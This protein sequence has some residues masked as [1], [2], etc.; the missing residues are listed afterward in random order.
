MNNTIA[1]MAINFLSI[2]VE[3]AYDKKVIILLDEFDSPMLKF[4]FNNDDSITDRENGFLES[5]FISTFRENPSL[6]RAIITGITQIRSNSIISGFSKMQ[7]IKST[8]KKFSTIFGFTY[9]EVLTSLT[10]YHLDYWRD[11][12]FKWYD[13]YCFS[14]S[15]GIGNPLSITKFM[16]ELKCLSCH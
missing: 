5:F 3:K 6:E 10:E 13:G 15:K 2:F 7:I 12:I 11:D 14:D 9:S 8:S 1:F 16:N 4:G